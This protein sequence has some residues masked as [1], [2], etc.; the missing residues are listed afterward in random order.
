MAFIMLRYVSSMPAVW[1]VFVIKGCLIFVKGFLCIYWDNHMVF[2]FQFVNVVYHI[3][4]KSISSL[5]CLLTW[6]QLITSYF[7]LQFHNYCWSFYKPQLPRL[8]FLLLKSLKSIQIDMNFE[9]K[10]GENHFPTEYSQ[11][12]IQFHFS[13]W[14]SPEVSQRS[15]N[16]VFNQRLE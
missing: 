7:P 14:N 15:V 8:Y 4:C 3:D 11:M 1:R 13:P 12:W 2:I 16:I 9:G 6:C 10:W 5:N